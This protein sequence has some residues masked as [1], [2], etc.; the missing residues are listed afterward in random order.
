MRPQKIADDQLL[1]ALTRVFRTK[2]YEGASLKELA[3]V[4]GLKKASL[5]HRFPDGK[6]E[7][8]ESVL[9]YMG[10]WVTINIFNILTNEKYPPETRLKHALVQIGKLYDG[11]KDGCIFRAFSMQAGL[12]LFQEGIKKGMN[13]WLNVFKNLGTAMGLSDKIAEENALQSL[14]DIQGS[15]ILSKGLQD[16]NI[17]KNTLKKIENRYG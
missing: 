5:Y 9:E 4:T 7:M 3:E 10:Q 17:F 1:P 16:N 12:D 13:D 15:L 11:G 8:A 6:Q 14:I 2:G